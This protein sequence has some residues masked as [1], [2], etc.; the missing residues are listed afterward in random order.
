MAVADA[1]SSGST[2]VGGLGGVI[3]LV[4][5]IQLIRLTK[6][7]PEGHPFPAGDARRP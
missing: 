1:I 6:P 4:V 2:P 3:M 5:G 7:A